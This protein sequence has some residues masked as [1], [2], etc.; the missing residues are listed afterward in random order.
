M[1]DVSPRVQR[2]NQKY[3][4]A[5]RH[6]KKEKVPTTTKIIIII[7][8]VAD[9]IKVWCVYFL[10]CFVFLLFARALMCRLLV[11]QYIYLA[12]EMSRKTVK[13]KW[14]RKGWIKMEVDDNVKKMDAG[15]EKRN[16]KQ[17]KKWRKK[18]ENR[19]VERIKERK[20]FKM[21]GH[22]RCSTD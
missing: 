1:R 13:I 20:G 14:E 3:R 2:L 7:T 6:K 12:S 19:K 15:E 16:I 5:A 10:F 22:R 8:T 21:A 18:N 9:C 11:C 17:K 4:E